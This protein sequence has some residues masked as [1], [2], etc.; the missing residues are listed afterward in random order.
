[1]CDM[2]RVVVWERRTEWP[3][4]VASIVF[5]AAYAIPIAVPQSPPTWKAVCGALIAAT[6]A[7][8]AADYAV[9]LFLA[10]RRAQFVRRNAFDLAVIVLPVLRP[11]RLLRLV[12]VLSVLNRQ[13][14]RSLRGRVAAYVVGGTALLLLCGGLAITEAERGKP[15][16][17]IVG[18]GDGLWW[19]ATTVTTVGYGDRYPVTVTGRLVA[20]GLMLGGIALLGVVTATLA[21]WLVERVSEAGEVEATATQAQVAALTDEVRALREE[22]ARLR[23]PAR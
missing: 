22:V 20:F 2:D 23:D 9:R 11:L 5:L 17:N 10:D 12:T 16:A 7:L 15:G 6:W 19:A 14:S 4:T 8:F 3:L 1:M 13:G 21:S 18:L